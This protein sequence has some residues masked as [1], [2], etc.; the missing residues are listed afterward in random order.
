MALLTELIQKNGVI[1]D[2]KSRFKFGAIKD[3]I[4]ELSKAN[5]ININDV[6]HILQSVIAREN[7][8]TT[9]VGYGVSLPHALSKCLTKC[10]IAIGLSKSGI[11]WEAMDRKPVYIVF[12]FLAPEFLKEDL[13]DVQCRVSLILKEKEFR[14][15]LIKSNKNNILIRFEEMEESTLKS[16]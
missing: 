12:L 4:I 3:I 6:E 8:V 14:E 13:I 9:G 2:L 10:I 11:Q 7:I 15:E 16:G 5:K 1:V